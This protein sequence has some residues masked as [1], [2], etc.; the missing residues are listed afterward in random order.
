MLNINNMIKIIEVKTKKQQ[1]QFINFP[2]YLYKKNK[3]FVPPLYMDEKKIFKKNYMYYDQC[4][5]VY[6]NAYI[7]NKVVGRISGIIQYASNEKN[8]E[9]RV[10]F[11]RFDSIDNQDVANALFNKV[12]NWAKSKGMDTI[13]G[14][15]GFSDLER[16][17][18][19][20][21]GFDELSTFEEQYNYDYYQRLVE[22]YGFEKEVDWVE[23]KLYKPK[24]VDDRLERVSSYMMKKNNLKFGTAKNKKEFLKKYADKFFD[25]IDETYYDIY[26]TVPF[27]KGMRDMMIS[28]FKLIINMKQVAVIVDEDDNVVCFGIC[29]PSIAKAVQKSK[30][31]LTPLAIIRILKSIKNPEIIDC[32]LIGVLP[33]Y[34]MRGISSALISEIMKMLSE[35]NVKYAETNLNLETNANI[36]N[37]WKSFDSI[38]HKRRRAYVKKID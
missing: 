9:K 35:G 37:Q 8:N 24:E 23:R 19:L 22:N 26:G 2:I 12:E 3:Y 32:G 33:K 7:D 17:G 5:A 6:Y 21:E 18:L 27:T 30:G 31:H 38:Q 4:E 11:T 1:K 13:V 15:L 20:V 14:P 16:E 34:A 29:F 28:N 25:I 10:R 36:Q